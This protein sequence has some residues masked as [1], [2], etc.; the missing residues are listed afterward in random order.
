M[1]DCIV[2]GRP[3][4]LTVDERPL[5][6]P[7]AAEAVIALE[8]LIDRLRERHKRSLVRID[9]FVTVKDFVSVSEKLSQ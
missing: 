2:C 5:C 1:D 6:Q 3:M 9:R 7:H 8:E 4:Y